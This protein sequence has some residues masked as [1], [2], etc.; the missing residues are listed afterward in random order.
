MGDAEVDAVAPVSTRA[1]TEAAVAAAKDALGPRAEAQAPFMPSSTPIEDSRRYMCWNSVGSITSRDEGG[2][3]ASIEI[4]FNDKN[5]HRAVRFSDRFE[6]VLGSLSD[7]AA[8]FANIP[9]DDVSG[10]CQPKVNI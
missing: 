2:V 5:S 3:V 6:L 9:L 4:D 8:A 1:V 10:K 7:Q